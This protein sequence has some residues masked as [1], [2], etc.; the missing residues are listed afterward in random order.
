MTE[1]RA[2][3]RAYPLPASARDLADLAVGGYATL[4]QPRMQVAF[5]VHHLADRPGYLVDYLSRPLESGFHQPGHG[6]GEAMLSNAYRLGFLAATRPKK[7]ASDNPYY[8]GDGVLS[9]PEAT[10]FHGGALPNPSFA[11]ESGQRYDIVVSIDPTAHKITHW[12]S[13]VICHLV[14]DLTNISAAYSAPIVSLQSPTQV[15]FS[16]TMGLASPKEHAQLPARATSVAVRFT[17]SVPFLGSGETLQLTEHLAEYCYDRGFGL[18][19]ADSHQS[20]GCWRMVTQSD[21]E[22]RQAQAITFR[23]NRGN[24]HWALPLTLVGPSRMKAGHAVM[25]VLSAYPDIGVVGCSIASLNDLAF[26]HLRL[27]STTAPDSVMREINCELDPLAVSGQSLEET[28]LKIVRVLSPDNAVDHQRYAA[29]SSEAGD[30]QCLIGPSRRLVIPENRLGIWFSWRIQEGV[31]S[32]A[33]P[34]LALYQGLADI[35]LLTR[36]SEDTYYRWRRESPNIEYLLF[37]STEDSIQH[38][39]GILSITQPA[40]WTA[41]KSEEDVAYSVRSICIRLEQAW[42]ARIATDVDQGVREVAVA[43]EERTLGD[44]TLPPRK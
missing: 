21:Q 38:A 35:S 20:A 40:G 5:E 7:R 36:E 3:P 31:V 32:Q 37:H 22:R 41:F 13:Q 16:D 18:W 42:S 29:L 10:V 6:L 25:S 39:V 9:H 26:I 23:A 14:N 2:I 43:T 44:W 28:L 11:Y 27:S 33:V 8:G 30:Y 34:L 19:L 15:P 24:V 12:H 4:H 17:I 1:P